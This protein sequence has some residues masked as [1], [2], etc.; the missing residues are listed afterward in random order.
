[1]TC[2]FSSVDTDTQFSSVDTDTQNDMSRDPSRVDTAVVGLFCFFIAVV[3]L[4]CFFS[5][6]LGLFCTAVVGLFCFFSR[7]RLLLHWVSFASVKK[8]GGKKYTHMK[9]DG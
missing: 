2:Q 1:M 9:R 8:R 5:A 6:V 7:S 3:G 4:F